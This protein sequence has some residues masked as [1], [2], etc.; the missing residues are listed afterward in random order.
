MQNRRLAPV[1][2]IAEV[3]VE[4][5]VP[6]ELRM[7]LGFDRGAGFGLASAKAQVSVVMSR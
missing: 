3:Q 1:E 4:R 7:G 2:A 5:P 6:S